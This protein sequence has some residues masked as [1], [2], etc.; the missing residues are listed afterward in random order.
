MRLENLVLY[1]STIRTGV[2][3]EFQLTPPQQCYM[4]TKYNATYLQS[5]VVWAVIRQQVRLA[6]P[7]G[8][9]QAP[10]I[11]H[12]KEPVKHQAEFLGL[13]GVSK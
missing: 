5:F 12:V 8:F 4:Y 13:A 10:N 3:V 6:F 7:P 2:H 9:L 11:H 1:G